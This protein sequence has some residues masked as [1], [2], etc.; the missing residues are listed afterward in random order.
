MTFHK[1]TIIVVQ[2]HVDDVDDIDIVDDYII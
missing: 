1:C 2:H